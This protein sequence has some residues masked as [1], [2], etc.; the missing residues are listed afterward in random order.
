MKGAV[1]KVRWRILTLEE[2]GEEGS[3]EQTDS[4]EQGEGPPGFPGIPPPFARSARAAI[5]HDH[6][7]RNG[8]V[9]RKEESIWYR[10]G[11]ALEEVMASLPPRS[12]GGRSPGETRTR[13]SK[14][15]ATPPRTDPPMAGMILSAG[16]TLLTTVLAQWVGKR[17]FPLGILARG[18]LAGA[19]A[20]GAVLALRILLRREEEGRK[21]ETLEEVGD[22][23]LAGAGRG[24]LYA[25]L[26]APL[27]PG[28]PLL[29]GA[30][31]GSADFLASPAGGLFSS[32]QR[33]S[34]VRKLP[35]LSALLETGDAEEDPYLTFLLHGTILGLLYGATNRDG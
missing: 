33:F 14:T 31:A 9:S 1:V 28:P 22:E 27:L 2:A 5:F 24:V 4:Q 16:S 12:G 34:P 25:T 7:K 29:R 8:T 10:L 23:L 6:L 3:T 13:K 26:L 32:L 18:A 17:R 30:L 11:W 20:A 21:V 15:D 19:G 35:I